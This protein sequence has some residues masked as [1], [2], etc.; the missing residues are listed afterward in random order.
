MISHAQTARMGIP[1]IAVQILF[2][3]IFTFADPNKQHEIVEVE[4][5]QI[6]HRYVC[7]HNTPA[8]FLDMLIYEGDLIVVGCVL[9]FKTRHLIEEYNEAK[10]LI[11]AMYDTAF[12]GSFLLVFSNVVVTYQAH[13]RL[14]A[15]VG[16]FWATCFASSVFVLP[17]IM[18]VRT[19]HNRS[20]NPTNISVNPVSNRVQNNVH[21]TGLTGL[22][23]TS[24]DH[25]SNKLSS[26]GEKEDTHSNTAMP[27]FPAG[28]AIV[29]C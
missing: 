14:V 27:T 8:F 6:T 29:N 16:I 18:Q 13:M 25:K 26:A 1:F 21:I 17:R 24:L 4:G 20:D 7:A 22:S 3:L 5:S 28:A 11:L 10:Q 19:R 15:V 23:S 12:V 2:L 9:A